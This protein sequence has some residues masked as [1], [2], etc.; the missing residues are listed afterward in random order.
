[1]DEKFRASLKNAAINLRQTT[2]MIS[3]EELLKNGDDGVE[4]KNR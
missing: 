4:N 3:E 2:M 1:M